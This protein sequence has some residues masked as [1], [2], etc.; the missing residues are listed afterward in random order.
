[1]FWADT[2]G[3]IDFWD[4]TFHRKF[5]WCPIHSCSTHSQL[6]NVPWKKIVLWK[7]YLATSILSMEKRCMTIIY[8]ALWVNPEISIV[9]LATDI[10]DLSKFHVDIGN[11]VSEPCFYWEYCGLW[12]VV[13]IRFLLLWQTRWSKWPGRAGY[14]ISLTFLGHWGRSSWITIIKSACSNYDDVNP[15]FLQKPC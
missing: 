13:L 1:M 8:Y 4:Q 5:C 3:S 2:R 14:I 6:W 12:G 7:I 11:L 15:W 9:Y 10:M